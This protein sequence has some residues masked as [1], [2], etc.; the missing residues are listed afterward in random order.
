[1]ELQFGNI[2]ATFGILLAAIL[3]TIICRS[4]IFVQKL[5]GK[6]QVTVLMNNQ[7]GR[8]ITKR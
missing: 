5:K 6:V 3:M 7:L 1:M 2:L 8:E 4:G